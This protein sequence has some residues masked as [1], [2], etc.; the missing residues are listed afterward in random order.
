[1]A[2]LSMCPDASSSFSGF[3]IAEDKKKKKKKKTFFNAQNC[4]FT[5]VGYLFSSHETRFYPVFRNSLAA[6]ENQYFPALC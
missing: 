3:S 1:M 5:C 6:I 4:N 2:K